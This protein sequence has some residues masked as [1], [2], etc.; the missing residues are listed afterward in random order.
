MKLTLASSFLL[1]AALAASNP[2]AVRSANNAK[3]SFNAKLMSSAR[4][5]NDEAEDAQV[6]ISG[7]SLVFQKC[8][9]IKAYSDD[10]AEDEDSETVLAT[11]RFVIFKLCSSCGSC[12]YNYGEYMIDLD[13]YLQ[14]AVEYQQEAQQ[15]MCEACDENCQADEEE[16]E[17]EEEAD[18]DADEEEGD[19]E[20]G[21]EEDED[22][23]DRKRRKLV[24]V[25]CDSCAATCE[26]LDDL[27]GAGYYDATDFIECQLIYD[28][29]DDGVDG[30]YA[31]PMCSSNGSKIKIGVFEDEDCYKPSYGKSVEDYIVDGNGYTMQIY[32]ATLKATYKNTCISCLV[33]EEEDE[34]EDADEDEDAEEEEEQEAQVL[35]MCANLYEEAAKC[36][37]IGGFQ[38]GYADNENY[39]NQAAQEDLV[40]DF[41]DSV[42]KGAY[43]DEGEISLYGNNKNVRGG[44]TTTGGQKFA[45]TFFV[46]G[47]VCLAVYAAMLHS[48]LSKGS[49]AGLSSQGGAMA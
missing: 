19:E 8:Q 41:I 33:E 9:F 27:E 1:G 14:A 32:D 22:N 34:N 43:D 38:N 16:E 30:L 26:L 45:L 42:K 7:Y 37:S 2:F 31:G 28:P 48:K 47:T 11:Q 21:D 5:L 25:D 24:D 46:V 15:E 39:E 35:D 36:E 49:S 18:E 29:E 17:E 23:E 10:M 4:R 44:S 12:N 13:D 6:D 3:A 40:C 20:E